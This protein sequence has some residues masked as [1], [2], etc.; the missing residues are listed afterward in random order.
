M[1]DE[2][3][4]IRLVDSIKLEL[5]HELKSLQE[6]ILETSLPKFMRSKTLQKYFQI[7]NSTLHTYYTNGLINKYKL[8]GTNYY[9]T[10]EVLDLLESSK[11]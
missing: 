2:D 6:R 11:E 9:K 3:R 4:F 1:N 5:K 10:Q 8:G 7:S